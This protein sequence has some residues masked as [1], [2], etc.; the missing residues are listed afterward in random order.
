[1]FGKKV[2]AL[3]VA[4]EAAEN[5]VASLKAAIDSSKDE[6]ASALAVEA[7]IHNDTVSERDILKAELVKKELRVKQLEMALTEAEARGD[8]QVRAV[9][10]E[11][12][13]MLV[14]AE[15][16]RAAAAQ[17]MRNLAFTLSG[18]G[19]V[20]TNAAGPSSNIASGIFQ[21]PSTTALTTT[22]L[23]AVARQQQR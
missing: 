2:L 11:M 19:G 20:S 17:Q 6:L 23:A 12:R 5:E 8:E 9:E 21:R 7:A 10:V 16:Q 13:A 14:D 15:R 1:M 3:E 22:A 18:S 4:R